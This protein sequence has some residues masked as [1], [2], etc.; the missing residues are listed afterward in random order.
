MSEIVDSILA[1][2]QNAVLVIHSPTSDTIQQ[3]K[4]KEDKVIY[5][6]KKFNV[7][8]LTSSHLLTTS[9]SINQI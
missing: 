1:K 4:E 2:N 3:E 7:K 5:I 6:Y 8:E 9:Y